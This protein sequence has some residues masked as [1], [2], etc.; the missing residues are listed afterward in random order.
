MKILR[1]L[2]NS[3]AIC[4]NGFSNSF[5]VIGKGITFGKKEGDEVDKSRIDKIY[6][7]SDKKIVDLIQQI[8]DEYFEMSTVIIRY[9]ER[10]LDQP[11]AD[12]AYFVISDHIRG[13]MY[14]YKNNIHMPFGF[15]QEAELFYRD[16]YRVGEWII[17]YLDAALNVELAKDEIG[18][19][20]IDLVNLIGND[21]G[22][23]KLKL[24]MEVASLVE[25]LVNKEF[26]YI[27]KSSFSYKRF[28]THL[29]Y[30]AYRF[31]SNK[32]YQDQNIKFDFDDDFISN[33]SGLIKSIDQKLSE[34]Y[35]HSM[36]K[37][38]QK[39][40]LLHLQRLIYSNN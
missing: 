27:D 31:V 1:K 40:L 6:T 15:M 24:I 14:R 16:E 30:Y 11:L 35:G 19:L 10:K 22:M 3:A 13:I 36:D 29:Q 20:T 12:D 7:R 33:T 37:I 26:P 17:D 23:K 8:P 21:N 34:K 18:F 9:A 4:S 38:E 28:K 25:K 39:Y 32:E 5:I 2:N